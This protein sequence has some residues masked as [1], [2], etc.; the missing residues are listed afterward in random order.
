MDLKIAMR[1]AIAEHADGDG[2]WIDFA[3]DACLK[4]LAAIVPD[5]DAMDA[6]ARAI[7]SYGCSH[8]GSDTPFDEQT[9]Q[10]RAMRLGEA[11]SAWAAMLG[12][13]ANRTPEADGK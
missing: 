12:S 7:A 2:A 9:V 11:R 10:F 8:F 3:V 1:D 5:G 4:K 13:I 6:G